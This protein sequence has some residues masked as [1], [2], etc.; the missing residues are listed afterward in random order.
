M[1][2]Q[3]SRTG[4]NPCATQPRPLQRASPVYGALLRSPGIHAWAVAVLKR[5]LQSVFSGM[6]IGIVYRRQQ[7]RTGIN[8]CATQPRPLKRASP[9]YGALLRSPGIHAWAVAVLKRYLQSALSGVVIGIVHRQS[10][11]GGSLVQA[12]VGGEEDKRRKTVGE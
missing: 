1:R 12:A 3:Q 9:V 6:V 11:S 5:H 4:I 10:F 8:P 7:S 2:L